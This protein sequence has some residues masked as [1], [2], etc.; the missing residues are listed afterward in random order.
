MTFSQ[1]ILTGLALGV[2]TGLFLGDLAAPLRVVADAF[3]RLLQMTVLPYVTVS[4]IVGIGSLDPA[5]S[6]LVK[7]RIERDFPRARKR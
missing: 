6:K 7:G 2:V 3:V 1:K 5:V 4:L